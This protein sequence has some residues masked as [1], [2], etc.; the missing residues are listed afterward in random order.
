MQH[1]KHKKNTCIYCLFV[2][3]AARTTL[4]CFKAKY[5]IKK[6]K[7]TLA[8]RTQRATMYTYLKQ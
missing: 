8:L 2:L 7:K 3:S 6:A 4:A 1:Q 5:N